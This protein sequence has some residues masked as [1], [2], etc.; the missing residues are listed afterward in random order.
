MSLNYNYSDELYH[1]GI[2][3]M[4]WGVRRYQNPDGSLNDAGLKRDAKLLDKTKRL[5]NSSSY[6]SREAKEYARYSQNGSRSLEKSDRYLNKAAKVANKMSDQGKQAFNSEQYKQAIQSRKSAGEDYVKRNTSERVGS[7]VKN[8]AVSTGASFC[9]MIMGMPVGVLYVS[10]GPKYKLSHSDFVDELIHWV[11]PEDHKYIEK[12]KLKNGKYR[13]FYDKEEYQNYIKGIDETKSD[14]QKVGSVK[15]TAKKTG[16]VDGFNG[17]SLFYT[18]GQLLDAVEKA[19]KVVDK[20][21]ADKSEQNKDKKTPKEYKYKEKIRNSK[22]EWVY[23]YDE[24]QYNDYMHRKDYQKNEPDFMKQLPKIDENEAYTRDENMAITNPNYDPYEEEYS[25]NCFKCT[26]A[27]D[28]R[29]RGYDVEAAEATNDQTFFTLEKYYEN[30]Q[31]YRLN[32]DGSLEDF[33]YVTDHSIIG[34]FIYEPKM[35]NYS[36]KTLKNALEKNNP[37]GSRGNLMVYWKD[38]GGHSVVYEVDN[39]GNAVIR[40]AQT[41]MKYDFD[42]FASCCRE[43]QFTRTD[44]LELKEDVLDAVVKRKRKY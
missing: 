21:F 13:Y 23:F 39:K 10:P 3:G 38:G 8:A 19:V 40:D 7:V 42:S 2:K 15:N 12:V 24:E 37:P 17:L 33:D 5:S 34:Q 16:K 30:P 28:L 18:R 9:G 11:S 6:Y 32:P 4:K 14:S 43:I 29:Q 41:N 22:G 1:F 27:Y 35:N 25:T 26:V 20:L 36:G 44:N 31:Q